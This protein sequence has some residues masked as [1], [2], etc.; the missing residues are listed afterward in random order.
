MAVVGALL[1]GLLL[2]WIISL[3]ND[4]S[5]GL[6]IRGKES[7]IKDYSKENAELLKANHQLELENTRL[8]AE[9]NAL[10]DDKSL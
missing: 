8:K 7:K 5:T 9:T 10:D 2:A 4:V 1:V 3:V 6:T